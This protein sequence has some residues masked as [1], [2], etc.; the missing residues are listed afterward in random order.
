MDVRAAS[1]LR[2]GRQ[3]GRYVDR[4]IEIGQWLGD[5]YMLQRTGSGVL[6]IF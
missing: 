5:R 2:D 4:Y 6:W 3:M 1:R